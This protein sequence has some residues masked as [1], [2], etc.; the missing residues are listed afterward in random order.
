MLERL[1][2]VLYAIE[3]L[4]ALIAVYTVWSEVGGQGH[5]D[6]MAWYWKAAIGPPAAYGVIRLTQAAVRR[7]LV[8]PVLGDSDEAKVREGRSEHL[9]HLHCVLAIAKLQPARLLVHT[10]SPAGPYPP[11]SADSR[12]L[13]NLKSPML[14]QGR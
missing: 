9:S 12:V 1:L 3:F 5:L 4:I 10:H 6:Y 8:L 13:N 14:T 11:P 7:G 2:H